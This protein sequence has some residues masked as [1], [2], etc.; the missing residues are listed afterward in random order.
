MSDAPLAPAGRSLFADAML[1]L[2]RNRAAVASLIVL[3]LIALAGILGPL[4][5]PNP[6]D[7]VFQ[8]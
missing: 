3:A 2:V 4:F 1:R 8:D 7:R 6:Y 5:A